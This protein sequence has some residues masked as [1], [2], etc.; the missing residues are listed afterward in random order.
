[1]VALFLWTIRIA[2][3]VKIVDDLLSNGFGKLDA[4][5]IK[6]AFVFIEGTRMLRGVD[7]DLQV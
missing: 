7:E 2:I 3:P 4:D 6:P 5:G 1:M